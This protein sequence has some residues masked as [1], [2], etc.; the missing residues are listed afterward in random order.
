MRAGAVDAPS[1][2]DSVIPQAEPLISS[3]F[4][5]YYDNFF[6]TNV[7]SRSSGIMAN[8]SRELPNSRNSYHLEND[9]VLINSGGE[10]EEESHAKKQYA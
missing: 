4:D 5:P 2:T 8:A 7:I 1:F 10:P 3:P 6:F 9:Q